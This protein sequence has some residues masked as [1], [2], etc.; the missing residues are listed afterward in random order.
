MVDIK[1]FAVRFQ[2]L[3]LTLCQIHNSIEIEVRIFLKVVMYLLFNLHR[4]LS[5]KGCR[6][7]LKKKSLRLFVQ[8][9]PIY[10]PSEEEK[11]DPALFASNVRHIMAKSVSTSNLMIQNILVLNA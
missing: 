5:L 2:I 6:F 1:C 3:W 10:T 8:Y 4:K 9:L 11:R 7:Q